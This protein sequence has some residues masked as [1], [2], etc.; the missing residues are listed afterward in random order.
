MQTSPYDIEE[1]KSI[2]SRNLAELPNNPSRICIRRFRSSGLYRVTV[3][4][5]EWQASPDAL[6]ASLKDILKKSVEELLINKT[7]Q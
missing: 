1:L 3:V 6:D 2:Y 5:P 4:F 7:K